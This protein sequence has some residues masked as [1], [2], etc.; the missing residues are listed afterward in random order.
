MKKY[1]NLIKLKRLNR[2][3]KIKERKTKSSKISEFLTI[4]RFVSTDSHV[5]SRLVDSKKL[6]KLLYFVRLRKLID[7]H[8]LNRWRMNQH[9][10]VIMHRGSES[11]HYGND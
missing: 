7:L 10:E 6:V 4:K 9:M 3:C 8:Q 11:P 2:N 1:K 5:G